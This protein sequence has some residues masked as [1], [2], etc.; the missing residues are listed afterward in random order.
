MCLCL[1]LC[2]FHSARF[3]LESGFFSV[4]CS[5]KLPNLLG[6]KPEANVI[7]EFVSPCGPSHR[8]CFCLFRIASINRL[9]TPFLSDLFVLGAVRSGASSRFERKVPDLQLSRD[10]GA[11]FGNSNLTPIGIGAAEA[12][13]YLPFRVGFCSARTFQ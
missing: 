2:V 6:R 12:F 13:C 1:C 8:F 10:R 5:R 4:E 9:S 7:S 11:H 3:K